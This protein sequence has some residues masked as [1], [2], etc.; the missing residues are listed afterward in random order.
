M[1]RC[2]ICGV[3]KELK[4]FHKHS[5]YLD[6]YHVR[7]IECGKVVGKNAKKANAVRYNNEYKERCQANLV[8]GYCEECGG[9][10][11]S[12]AG[13]CSDCVLISD[14]SVLGSRLDIEKV[15]RERV[16]RMVVKKKASSGIIKLVGC[17]IEEVRTYIASKFSTGMSW[18]TY[19]VRGWHLDHVVPCG[20]YNLFNSV[21][22][23]QCFHYSNLQ[24]L[25]WYDNVRKS[26]G[27]GK[28]QRVRDLVVG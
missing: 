27:Y 26:D 9:I 25:W 28:G 19:G 14:P 6:G 12:G 23:K 5:M 3:T 17:G 7:C 18:D 10:V 21:E 2:V 20:S 24:P 1:R 13:R 4:E 11:P 22:L 15:F 16:K 8:V